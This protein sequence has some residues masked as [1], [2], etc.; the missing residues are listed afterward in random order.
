MFLSDVKNPIQ[1]ARRI[2]DKAHRSPGM[3][4]VPPNFLCGEG[5]TDFAWH[6]KVIVVPDELM[7]APLSLQRWKTWCKEIADHER[8]NPRSDSEMMDTSLHRPM[9]STAA[10][11]AQA[12]PGVQQRIDAARHID[13]EPMD[14][15]KAKNSKTLDGL[16]PKV[17]T[18]TANPLHATS[19]HDMS[20]SHADHAPRLESQS[21]G[22]SE[23]AT[24]SEDVI[25]DTVGCIVVDKYGNIAAGSSSGG[26]GMKHRGRIGPAALI[27]IG[28]HVIPVDPGD[29]DK[30]SVAV[31]ASGTG[32]HIAS[33]FAASTCASRIYYNQ[34]MS[35]GGVYDQ[36]TE[37]EA[38]SSM[39]TNEFTGMYF[40]Y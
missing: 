11:L 40:I 22:A 16:I 28:T 31:V 6:N 4:R 35:P 30:S 18:K 34:R 37:E 32:E 33:T 10:R 3:S 27:G 15:A 24:G 36:V 29:P 17:E 39:L 12:F 2:Y 25:S 8:E 20:T 14:P 19:Q 23:R 1:L 7:I 38:I 21:L 26:I 13:E 5:A 9:S